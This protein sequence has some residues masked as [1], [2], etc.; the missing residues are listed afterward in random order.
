MCPG[1][2]FAHACNF[3]SMTTPVAN[4]RSTHAVRFGVWWVVLTTLGCGVG[5]VI[6]RAVAQPMPASMAN[7]LGWA[8]NGACV[9]AAQW[10]MLRRELNA[11]RWWTLAS[12]A[13]WLAGILMFVPGGTFL[14]SLLTLWTLT[15]GRSV[16]HF[17]SGPD[18]G[19]AV[20]L[21][22][23]IVQWLLLRRELT[24][25][26]W[27][28]LATALAWT[29]F[30]IP[31]GGPAAWRDAIVLGILSGLLTGIVLVWRVPKRRVFSARNP[32]RLPV[33][34]PR[35]ASPSK[36]PLSML[37]VKRTLRGILVVLGGSVVFS[38]G[39]WIPIALFVCLIG[40]LIVDI[41]W[42]DKAT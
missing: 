39:I 26:G 1:S 33:D 2:Y 27:W 24:G 5:S 34:D 38:H 9:G 42:P 23:G 37:T 14:Y 10:I 41:L 40:W 3:S 11:A 18:N 6:A 31:G 8:V 32:P 36:Q 35:E 19:A 22:I 12:A 21:S 20:G 7:L 25:A 4:T 13:G 17:F 16:P 28:V 29:L 15:L 30:Y